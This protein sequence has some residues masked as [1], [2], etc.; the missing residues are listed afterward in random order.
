MPDKASQASF[1]FYH[2]IHHL[3][4]FIINTIMLVL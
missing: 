2:V 4:N 3:L 1:A